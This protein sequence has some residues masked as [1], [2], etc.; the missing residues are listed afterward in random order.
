[1]LEFATRRNAMEPWIDLRLSDDLGSDGQ[2]RYVI[3]RIT[4]L[5][6]VLAVSPE[7]L[8]LVAV[9]GMTAKF[10]TL[11]KKVKVVELS[12]MSD[13]VN[14]L[15]LPYDIGLMYWSDVDV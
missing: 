6:L 3:H 4:D 14:V 12:K 10:N 15:P 1:M 7:A 5:E 2:F 11:G 13:I 8:W 9:E